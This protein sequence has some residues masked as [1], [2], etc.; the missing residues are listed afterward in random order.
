[1]LLFCKLLNFRWKFLVHK[2]A[3]FHTKKRRTQAEKPAAQT[4]HLVFP[5]TKA[6]TK[7]PKELFLA[8]NKR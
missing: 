5:N 6:N 8:N 7:K 2:I 1:L 3:T 4:A